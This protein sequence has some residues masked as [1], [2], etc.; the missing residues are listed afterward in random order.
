MKFRILENLS[1]HDAPK[2]R[3][4]IISVDPD[5]KV[6]TDACTNTVE[7]DSWLFAEEFLVAFYDAGYD[8]RIA[9]R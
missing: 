9:Q 5:A 8:V 1:D 4:A 7:V 2:I 3:S 6:V